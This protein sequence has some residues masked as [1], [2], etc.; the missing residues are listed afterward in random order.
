MIMRD[1]IK[2]TLKM[3]EIKLLFTEEQ[4]NKHFRFL[5]KEIVE[6][7]LRD[8]RDYQGRAQPL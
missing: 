6:E 8:I 1:T 5:T 2:I 3:T 7:N 4:Y